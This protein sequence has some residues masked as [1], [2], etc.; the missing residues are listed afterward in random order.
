MEQNTKIPKMKHFIFRDP[1][2]TTPAT[3]DASWI[4]ETNK[5]NR[6]LYILPTTPL[7]SRGWHSYIHNPYDDKD[8]IRSFMAGYMQV[9]NTSVPEND[10][11]YLDTIGKGFTVYYEDKDYLSKINWTSPVDCIP[12]TPQLKKLRGFRC[13]YRAINLCTTSDYKY[14]VDEFLLSYFYSNK[15]IARNT[16]YF[17]YARIHKLMRSP[18]FLK[19]IILLLLYMSK[20]EYMQFNLSEIKNV[21][22]LIREI[23]TLRS[24]PKYSAYKTMP[25]NKYLSMLLGM[26]PNIYHINSYINSTD[27]FY[28]KNPFKQH[29]ILSLIG[30]YYEKSKDDLPTVIKNIHKIIDAYA[31]FQKNPVLNDEL[32]ETIGLS[33]LNTAFASQAQMPLTLQYE[34]EIQDYNF[35][36]ENT[37][38]FSGFYDQPNII[39]NTYTLREPK[40]LSSIVQVLGTNNL[41][42]PL[43]VGNYKL[44]PESDELV[45]KLASLNYI[46]KNGNIS[47]PVLTKLA[48]HIPLPN[49]SSAVIWKIINAAGYDVRP[50]W[51][52]H[53]STDI[54]PLMSN[55]RL[56]DV[57]AR[58]LYILLNWSSLPSKLPTDLNSYEPRFK[59]RTIVGGLVYGIG[60]IMMIIAI[61]ILLAFLI[62][63]T[64]KPSK[65][66]KPY[67]PSRC[68]KA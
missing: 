16:I 9:V 21:G 49:V 35:D 24:A 45:N 12:N 22:D 1:H 52:R 37:E 40:E 57:G 46:D 34:N 25:K 67:E 55:N 4:T 65:P 38:Y 42:I 28:I 54:S 59:M 20:N 36:C 39:L 7:Y 44:K 60:Y 48:E 19:A 29:Y 5:V 23:E 62:N 6:E 10:H 32:M 13:F 15:H 47:D 30:I 58:A 50:E 68:N 41:T 26:V 63:K 51:Y 31:L 64:S 8:Y 33:C 27:G 18:V 66:S 43:N 61:I 14:G 2:A 3:I 11:V 17:L 53:S 56:N